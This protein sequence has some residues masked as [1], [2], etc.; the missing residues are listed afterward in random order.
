MA[1]TGE[2]RVSSVLCCEWMVRY[3]SL[4]ADTAI[5]VRSVQTPVPVGTNSSGVATAKSI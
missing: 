2:G 5:S 1:S 3:Q 4:R